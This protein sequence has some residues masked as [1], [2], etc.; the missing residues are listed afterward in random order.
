MVPLLS[1]PRTIT[2]FRSRNCWA[3]N[4]PDWD[5]FEVPLPFQEWVC[6]LRVI[7]HLRRLHPTARIIFE[8]EPR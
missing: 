3:A 6:A 8:E 2:I 4:I 1:A 7:E 5:A